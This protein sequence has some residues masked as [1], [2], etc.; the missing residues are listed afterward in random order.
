M[1]K[2]KD[3]R[4]AL[5]DRGINPRIVKDAKEPLTFVIPDNDEWFNGL[6]I[7]AATNC[8]VSKGCTDRD[9]VEWAWIGRSRAVIEFIDGKIYRYNHTTKTAKAVNL[10]DRRTQASPGTYEL[11]PP[12][13]VRKLGTK[14]NGKVKIKGSFP[15]RGKRNVKTIHQ[16]PRRDF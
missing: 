6:T 12:V 3:W 10:H 15:Q 4:E 16:R 13:G 1:N 5:R 14:R 9:N 11:K 8:A 2:T 7:N